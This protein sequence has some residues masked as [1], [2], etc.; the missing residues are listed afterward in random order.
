MKRAEHRRR[1]RAAARWGLGL[2][3][4]FVL[5]ASALA[6]AAAAG[7]KSPDKD[8]DY[9]WDAAQGEKLQALAAKGDATRG[10]ISF[11]VCQ[12][13]HRRHAQGRPDGSYPRL[14]GQ[15]RSVLIKQMTDVRAGR[16][17]ND[18]M[19][20][21]VDRHVIGP[22]DIA[23]IA[24]YLSELPVGSD[25][26]KG[27]GRDQAEA[28]QLYRFQ[29]V[30]CHG[31]QGQGDAARFYPRVNGQHYRYLRREMIAIRDG[32]RGNADP[33]MVEIVKPLSDAQLAALADYMSRL[34]LF[35]PR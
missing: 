1:A 8:S 25:N 29:C 7:E 16:R 31:E 26:G 24:V 15:H 9:T 28:E 5:H 21:F 34:P 22:Q 23:D 17:R 14:A 3:A 6:Q 12:G 11:E 33:K 18:T 30:E 27:P 4:A 13:C 35:A 19:L 2:L 32:A 10:E 20:P